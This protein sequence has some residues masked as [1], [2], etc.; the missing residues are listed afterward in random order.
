LIKERLISLRVKAKPSLEQAWRTVLRWGPAKTFVVTTASFVALVFIWAALARVDIIVRADGRVVP[1]G[2]AQIV[3]HL[4]GGIVQAIKVH[5]GQSVE[6]GQVLMELSDVKA[7]ADL[8]QE[9]TR[10]NALRGR[11]ARLLAEAEGRT[12]IAFPA[13]LVDAEVRHAEEVA[14]SARQSRKREE[15][16]VLREQSSQK[17]SEINEAETRRRNITSELEVAQKQ[18]GIIED[19]RR[20]GAASQL[21]LLETQG[22]VQRLLSQQ[23]ETEASIPRLRAAVSETESR[24]A[25]TEAK[26]RAEASAELTQ[27]RADLEKSRFEFNT[28]ADRLARIQVIAPVSG[29]INRVAISTVGGVIRPGDT[30]LEITPASE[31]V[32]IEGKVRPNDRANLRNGQPARIRF[33]AYDYATF[34]MLNGRVDE[35]SADTLNEDRGER[36]YRVRL[37]AAAQAHDGLVPLPGMTAEADIV[38]GKRTVLSYILSPL[39]RF[40]DGAFR[41]PR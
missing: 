7:K 12:S 13:D 32:V 2:R 27:V 37:S 38:V 30:L 16:S 14:M 15:A 10:L 22:R 35:V 39:L 34:G 5:E 40:R 25:E 17:R 24:I 31:G 6:A 9:Q 3:Q 41:D 28:G 4:E 26:F 33:G 8:G 23:R 11:E 29:Y 1:A 18:A 20:K 36:Y 19:L 21:E